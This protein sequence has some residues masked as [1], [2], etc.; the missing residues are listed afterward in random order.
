MPASE[1]DAHLRKVV[2]GQLNRLNEGNFTSILKEL[3]S[4]YGS[5]SRNTMNVILT[6][7]ILEACVDK[8]EQVLC[9][10]SVLGSFVG[11]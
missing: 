3:E 1:K 5:H 4:L 9:R 2:R 11:R 6:D 8:G 10:H 7:F